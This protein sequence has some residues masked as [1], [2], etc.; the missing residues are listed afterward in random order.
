M[1]Y[2]ILFLA[3][4]AIFLISC[5]TTSNQYEY[6]EWE[7]WQQVP[8]SISIEVKALN[9][10]GQSDLLEYEVILKNVSDKPLKIGAGKSL[11]PPKVEFDIAVVNDNNELIWLR[12]PKDA[13][14]QS[15]MYTVH[16]SPRESYVMK[17]TWN[18]KDIKGQNVPSGEYKLYAG[19]HGLEITVLDSESNVSLESKNFGEKPVGSAPT[20]VIVQ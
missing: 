10:V 16:L 7:K 13:V 8:E 3:L 6:S 5:S 1:K 12:F 4:L 20:Q 15:I 19:L 18:L 2:S 17:D 14:T 9:N 11:N